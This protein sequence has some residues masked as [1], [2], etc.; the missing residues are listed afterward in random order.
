MKKWI[1]ILTSFLC[2]MVFLGCETEEVTE[3]VI[4]YHDWQYEQGWILEDL[5]EHM[6]GLGFTN[7]ETKSYTPTHDYEYGVWA[8]DI[9]GG[10]S[11]DI[12]FDAGDVFK[13]TSKVTIR[14]YDIGGTLTIDNCPELADLISGKETNYWPF[15]RKYSG[16]YIELDGF[17]IRES[18]G[19]FGGVFANTVGAGDYSADGYS[20]ITFHV[21]IEHTWFVDVLTSEND[22]VK[23]IGRIDESWS[24]Y[25]DEFYVG[26]AYYQLR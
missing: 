22:N 17:I 14:Y 24:E 23:V 7:I 20:G 5:V 10:F 4:P 16:K 8:I 25:W 12:G 6:E 26:A 3:I 15:V 21:N 1:V 19:Q 2:A 9:D 13:S 11:D 18:H